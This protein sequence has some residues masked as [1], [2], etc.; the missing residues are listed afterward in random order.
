MNRNTR[1]LVVGLALLALG[2]CKLV[3]TA[4]PGE[5]SK[6]GSDDQ[7]IADVVQAT[8]DAKLKPLIAGEAVDAAALLPAIAAGIDDTGATHGKKS[9][10]EG[11]SW[12]FPIKGS[13]TVTGGDRKSRAAKLDVDIN[14]DGKPDLSLQLGPVVKGTALRDIAPFYDF[15][16]FRDQIQFAQL[17]RALN[18]RATGAITLPD[19]DLA[20]R[21]VRFEG[22]FSVRSAKD[23][24]LVA[25]TGLEIAP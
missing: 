22:A 13:G 20:G 21:R 5:A 12:T 16:A 18:D 7:K 2:G 3:K 8:Y 1:A 6:A 23:L 15:T 4:D 25:P 11:G 10:G 24:V 17:A 9:G 14:G 19:G